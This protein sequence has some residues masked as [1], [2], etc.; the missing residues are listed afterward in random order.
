MPVNEVPGRRPFHGGVACVVASAEDSF[1]ESDVE[2]LVSDEI[3]SNIMVFQEGEKP[4]SSVITV[5]SKAGTKVKT[6]SL[7]VKTA[8]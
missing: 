3:D 1:Q 6:V 5:T 8:V 4:A 7:E 2:C